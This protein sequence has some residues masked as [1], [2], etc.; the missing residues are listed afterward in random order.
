MLSCVF[1]Y[2]CW[3]VFMDFGDV[4]SSP[5]PSKTLLQWCWWALLMVENRLNMVKKTQPDWWFGT[6]ILF[7]HDYWECHHPNWLSYFSEGWPNHQP[8]LDFCGGNPELLNSQENSA[9][10]LVKKWSAV[11]M[12]GSKACYLWSPKSLVN[13][14]SSPKSGISYSDLLGVGKDISGEITYRICSCLVLVVN[15]SD[16]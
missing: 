7:S 4:F 13:G 3:D 9:F 6:S 15:P 5:L 11:A 14:Y 12:D 10:N 1:F 8:S 2:F 16:C